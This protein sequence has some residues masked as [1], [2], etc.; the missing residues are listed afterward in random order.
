M[1]TSVRKSAVGV[2][3]VS[4]ELDLAWRAGLDLVSRHGCRTA[5]HSPARLSILDYRHDVDAKAGSHECDCCS[6]A[7]DL[8]ILDRLARILFDQQVIDRV[9]QAIERFLVRIAAG[10]VEDH[11]DID[12]ID[13][14]FAQDRIFCER[15]CLHNLG[16]LDFGLVANRLCTARRSG[17]QPVRDIPFASP[18]AG[19]GRCCR[20]SE[21][22]VLLNAMVTLP[23]SLAA[24]RMPDAGTVARLARL[25]HYRFTK[26]G[27]FGPSN[28][29]R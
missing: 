23:I 15:T 18:M 22:A 13:V 2:L 10:N 12:R 14:R 25:R 29:A 8:E 5:S 4:D 20:S 1:R 28:S 3:A 11:I 6:L 26:S 24:S 17:G 21:A 16:D 7:L 9:V 19:E 27:Q